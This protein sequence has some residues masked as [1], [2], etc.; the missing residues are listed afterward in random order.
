MNPLGFAIAA[1]LGNIVGALAVVRHE[2]RS[3]QAI[4]A[5]LAFGAG[6]M[7]AVAVLGTA[8]RRCSGTIPRRRSTCSSAIWPFT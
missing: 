1:A 2:R 4:D 7:L 3:L 8:A 6:F 5:G